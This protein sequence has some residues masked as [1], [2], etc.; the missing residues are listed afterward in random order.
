[1]HLWQLAVIARVFLA[2]CWAVRLPSAGEDCADC[3][4]ADSF[5]E[6]LHLHVLPQTPRSRLFLAKFDFQI[7]G[8]SWGSA[9]FDL[10]PKA[11]GKLLNAHPSIVGFEAALTQGRWKADQWGTAPYEFRSPG[12]L[13]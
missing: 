9:H 3:L 12:G 7:E 2:G 11:I 6:A 8:L 4:K 13:L 1:M 5:D 10:F